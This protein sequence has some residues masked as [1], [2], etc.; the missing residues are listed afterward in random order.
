MIAQAPPSFRDRVASGD[1]LAG[2]FVKTPAFEVIEVLALSG[3]DFV[4]LDA[5]HAPFDRARLDACLA[6]AR[7]LGLPALVR[8]PDAAPATLLQALDAGAAGVVVPHVTSGAAAADL[9]RACRFGPGGRGFAGSTRAAGYGS[10]TMAEVLSHGGDPIVI[11]QIEDPEGVE[12]CEAI[13]GTAGIDGVFLGPADLSVGYGKTDQTSDVL[14]A[15]ITRV[16]KAAAAAGKAYWTFTPNAAKA[17]DWARFG[18]TGFLLASEHAWML[19]GARE[20]VAGI[21]AITQPE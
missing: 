16:G 19:Q 5:E 4:I 17:A 11:A 3:L 9:A 6:I 14:M 18:F 1:L 10:R 8:V 12:N 13:A 21:R 7:A 20:A 2:T 15:A